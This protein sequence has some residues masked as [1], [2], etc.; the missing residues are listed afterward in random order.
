MDRY[1]HVILAPGGQL[2]PTEVAPLTAPIFGSILFDEIRRLILASGWLLRNGTEK[3]ARSIIEIA[4]KLQLDHRHIVTDGVS[5]KVQTIRTIRIHLEDDRVQ[6]VTP[7]QT[8][9]IALSSLR[10][11]DVS[12]AAVDIE[13]E[14]MLDPGQRRAQVMRSL[15]ELLM[16]GSPAGDLLERI[17]E[18][19]ILD[20]Q[21][22]V[23]LLGPD[24]VA[25]SLDRATVF[26]E[27]AA[28]GAVQSLANLLR[29]TGMLIGSLSDEQTTPQTQRM[30]QEGDL[31]GIRRD[32]PEE[33]QA[34]IEAL[35]TWT[36]D[37]GSLCP[38]PETR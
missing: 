23:L 10:A 11:L 17:S 6:V 30:W 25:W 33:Q 1:H 4:N 34:R 20:P 15:A 27:L 12:L 13:E 2:V 19:P 31:E 38:L 28:Q 8:R 26:P 18:S 24:A 22:R 36:Q 5:T 32:S 37:G 29:F 16:T 3:E 35:H 14:E 9:W 21:P 7:M